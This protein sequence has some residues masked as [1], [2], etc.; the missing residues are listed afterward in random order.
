MRFPSL[1]EEW[2]KNICV[3]HFQVKSKRDGL[4]IG[5]VLCI[6]FCFFV[7]AL[8]I[9][10]N[11]IICEFLYNSLEVQSTWEIPLKLIQHKLFSIELIFQMLSK[12]QL[13][14]NLEILFLQ[15]SWML[16]WIKQM[17]NTFNTYYKLYFYY[18]QYTGESPVCTCITYNAKF[19]GQPIKKATCF[20]NT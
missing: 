5:L 15:K 4:S 11:L 12:F 17:A 3:H 6:Q 13:G 20:F 2:I 10:L 7:I 18:A 16:F 19:V 9:I 1:S 8:L 14:K